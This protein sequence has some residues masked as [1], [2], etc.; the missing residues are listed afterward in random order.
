MPVEQA[1]AL[2]REPDRA[3]AGQQADTST[4]ER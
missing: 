1:I 2:A 4:E 3:N